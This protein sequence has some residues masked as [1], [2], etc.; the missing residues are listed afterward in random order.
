MNKIEYIGIIEE[1]LTKGPYN[2]NLLRMLVK[3]QKIVKV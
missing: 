3:L 1:M 2:K